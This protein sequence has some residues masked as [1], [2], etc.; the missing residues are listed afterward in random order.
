LAVAFAAASN[1]ASEVGHGILASP[2]SVGSGIAGALLGASGGSTIN[3]F[4][5]EQE[6]RE[7]RR[8]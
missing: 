3:P 8:Q 4:D 2:F 7:S 5:Q 6:A 1:S